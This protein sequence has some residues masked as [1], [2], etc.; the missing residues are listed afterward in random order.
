MSRP[1]GLVRPLAL[2][3]A[4][5]SLTMF[6]VAS[7]SASD[8][9]LRASVI[10]LDKKAS[11]QLAA[12]DVPDDEK[13]PTFADDYS[14]AAEKIDGI[15]AAYGEQIAKQRG[16]TDAGR[17]ARKLLL[18]SIDGTRKLFRRTTKIALDALAGKEP[19]TSDLD[20]VKKSGEAID[21]DSRRAYK[22]LKIKYDDGPASGDKNGK[23]AAR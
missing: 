11:K 19:S 22:L 16:S 7:A 20:K 15:F 10:S 13:S 9:S 21:R 4:V 8:K 23:A 17:T 12:V 1:L 2:L 14:A 3:I 18:K 6:S 5:L